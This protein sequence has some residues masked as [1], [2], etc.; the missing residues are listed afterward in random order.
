MDRPKQPCKK[1]C[2]DRSGECHGIC[3]K[4][5]E[6]E[7]ARN[8]YYQL[9]AEAYEL[10]YNLNEIEREGKERRRTRKRRRNK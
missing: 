7:K 3:K 2:P 1:D 10:Q 6:Y 9:R 4:W 5:L 8:E